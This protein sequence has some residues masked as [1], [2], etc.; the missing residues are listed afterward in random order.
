MQVI[1]HTTKHGFKVT[2][3]EPQTQELQNAMYQLGGCILVSCLVP[4]Y[5]SWLVVDG[6]HICGYLPNHVN[7][8]LAYFLCLPNYDVTEPWHA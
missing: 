5:F 4:F 7:V 2:S 6:S 1:E 3:L 8:V